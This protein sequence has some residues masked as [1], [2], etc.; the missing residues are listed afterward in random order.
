M[1]P[2]TDEARQPTHDDLIKK[3]LLQPRLLAE[4]FRAFLPQALEFADLK[5]IEYLDKE[6]PRG[7]RRPRRVGDLLVKTRWRDKPA[8]FLIHFE[9]QNRPEDIVMERLGEYALRDGIRYKMPVMPVLLLT[10]PK[11]EKAP[12]RSLTWEFGEL[13]TIHVRCP[14]LHFR[15]M[16]PRPHLESRNVVALAMSALMKLDAGQQVE[17]IVQT[18]AECV[19]QRLNP[20]DQEAALDFVRAYIELREEQLLQVEE[21]VRIL[22]SKEKRLIAMPKLINPFIE[23]GKLKGRAEGRHDG[24]FMVISRLFER[25]F[26]GMA[27]K[28]APLL[29]RLDEENLLAFGEAL[30]FIETPAKCMAWLKQRA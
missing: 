5:H 21:R 20:E 14:V 3:L 9:S 12:L 18:L 24:E 15:L 23:L 7:K 25:K 22:A 27:K 10:Y 16:D 4:F 2:P 1:K 13:A 11:P 19:R 29:R 6:H 28:A 17:A 8:C 30:L 26:P